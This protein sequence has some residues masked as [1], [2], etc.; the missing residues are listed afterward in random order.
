MTSGKTI[1]FS[2]VCLLM[3]AACSWGA[4]PMIAASDTGSASTRLDLADGWAIQSSANV[5]A[6]GAELSQPGFSTAG[7]H[8]AT[9]PSTVVAA[10]VADGTYPDPYFGMN[11]RSLPGADYPI[12]KIFSKLP[13]PEGSPFRSSWWFRTEFATSGAFSEAPVLHF[14]GINYRAEIWLNGER[15][16]DPGEIAGA[17][18]TYELD[19]TGRLRSEGLNALAVEVFPPQVDDLAITWVDWNPM[20]PD[21]AMGIWRDVYLTHSGPVSLRHPHVVSDLDLPGLDVARLTMSVEVRNTTDRPASG[22]LKARIDSLRMSEPVSLQ[23]GEE[24]TV[25]LTPE[26]Y[27]QLV[28][29]RPELWWPIHMGPQNLHNLELSFEIDGVASDRVHS[30]FGIRKIT[31]ELTAEGH[32]L[33]RVNGRPVLVRGAG[34]TPDMMLRFSPERM[35]SEL[36]Y[37]RDMGLNTIRLEG[38]MEPESF[39]ELTDELGILVMAGWVCCSHWERWDNWSDEDYGI[40]MESLRSQIRRLRQHP[41]LLVW[42]NASDMPPPAKVEKGYLEVLDELRWPNPV[43]SSASAKPAE[44]SGPSGVK[45]NGP[46]EWIP[47]SYWL[48]DDGK[49]GGAWGFATEVGP[50]PVV[51]PLES[52]REMLPE[53]SLWPIDEQWLF[54][55]GSGRFDNLDIFTEALTARYGTPTDAPDYAFKA[56]LLAYDGLRA[57]FEAYARNKYTATGVIQ[58][59]LNDAWPSMIWHLYDVY[60][61]PGGAYFGAKKALE[62]IHVQYSYDDR[63]VVIVNGFNRI[64]DEVN[65]SAQIYDLE[66]R[67]RFSKQLAVNVPEDSAS[68]AFVVPEIDDLSTTYFL[69]LT[70]EDSGGA[71]LSRNFY[72]LSTQTDVLDW[73]ASTYYHTPVKTHGDLTGLVTLPTVELTMS[74][75]HEIQG[76]E[77]VTVVNLENPTEHLAFAVHLR[78]TAG[79]GGSEILPILW[80][81]N[82]FPLLPGESRQIEARYDRSNLAGQRPTVVLDGWNMISATQHP[83]L[84]P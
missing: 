4:V 80:Q 32:R 37:V 82:Y 8:P 45:M 12:G 56:Q 79:E 70:L 61:R 50:G 22:M 23:P 31:S 84:A 69:Q 59:M 62:P 1:G 16:A 49:H 25:V 29:R 11:L 30:R 26:R 52:L 9:V 40:A 39:F 43:L 2:L 44:Y 18:R 7:W 14:D 58:W 35:A 47:P 73:N 13:M 51:P 55:A 66:M 53:S 15:L 71:L 74:A 64:L 34:W 21:K 75:T 41:S 24:R 10:L 33:F 81:D 77:G 6:S 28:V 27:P 36:A 3:A 17:Y 46:Y 60:L 78:L 38:K 42:L 19:V 76:N 68:R 83:A 67:Q 20:A 48:S 65:V 54:H 5:E 63:S 57:M 72:A